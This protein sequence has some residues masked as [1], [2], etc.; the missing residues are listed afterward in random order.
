MQV[1]TGNRDV[2]A[3]DDELP[4][5]GIRKC[6]DGPASFFVMY[7][8]GMKQRRITLGPVL[9]G[10]LKQMRLLRRLPLRLAVRQRHIIRAEHR[11]GRIGELHL[12]YRPM[13]RAAPDRAADDREVRGVRR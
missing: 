12:N 13:G 5:F 2:Q 6:K 3:F 11:R 7:Q 1:P 10:N 9:Q 8:R 4:G